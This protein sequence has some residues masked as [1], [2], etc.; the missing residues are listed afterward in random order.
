[1]KVYLQLFALLTLLIFSACAN[2]K[3][4]QDYSPEADFSILQTYS[5]KSKEQKKTGNARIDNPLLNNRIR[6]TVERYLEEKGYQKVAGGSPDVYISYEYIIDS[7]I[8]SEG[9]SFGFGV[10]RST[11]GR[12]GG[13]S[14]SSGGNVTERDEATLIIDFMDASTDDLIWRG[15]GTRRTTQ[16]S[17]PEQKNREINELVENILNQFPPVP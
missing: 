14:L 6:S 17:S 13:V 2:V 15:S 7:K 3:V 8:V 9:S 1:M 12:H 16:H 11:R 5:W 4:S 10:G